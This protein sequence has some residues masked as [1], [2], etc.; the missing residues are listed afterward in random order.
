[1]C[2]V[3]D[4]CRGGSVRGSGRLVCEMELQHD[5]KLHVTL[6]VHTCF[7][8]FWVQRWVAWACEP[9]AICCPRVLQVLLSHRTAASSGRVFEGS[10]RCP[11]LVLGH[12]L[13]EVI[14]VAVD[15]KKWPMLGESEYFPRY[16]AKILGL[17]VR[18]S[19]G[20]LLYNETALR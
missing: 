18:S 2:F 7:W 10:H 4:G 16:F 12:R 3:G 14:H 9:V 11:K 5:Q 20:T 1:M 19:L 6:L 17:R 15:C 13:T 8:H